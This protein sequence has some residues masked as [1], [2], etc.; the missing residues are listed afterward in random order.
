[1][2]ASAG[3]RQANDRSG[4]RGAVVLCSYFTPASPTE[5]MLYEDFARQ[6]FEWDEIIHVND[7]VV[8]SLCFFRSAEL[9]DRRIKKMC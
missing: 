1:M 6:C 9:W 5:R 4:L 2:L 7:L 3:L 8:S